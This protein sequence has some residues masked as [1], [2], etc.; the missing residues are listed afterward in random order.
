M[1]PDSKER[2]WKEGRAD[3][4]LDMVSLRLTRAMLRPEDVCKALG[5]EPSELR[6][7]ISRHKNRTRFDPQ[8]RALHPRDE[9][10]PKG[11]KWCGW[12]CEV[13]RQD[14]FGVNRRTKDGLHYYC[15][16]CWNEYM[17]AKKYWRGNGTTTPGRNV[18]SQAVPGG[19]DGARC[20][21]DG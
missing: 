8:K 19:R 17:K 9:Q 15:R 5:I 2:W 11:Y 12:C 1:K 18:A 21:Q 6:S 16:S 3:A 20:A 4:I 10:I 7:A 14:L 13:K